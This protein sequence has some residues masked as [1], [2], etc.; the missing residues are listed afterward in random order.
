MNK[1]FAFLLIFSGALA[2]AEPV[3]WHLV[4]IKFADGGVASGSFDYDADTNTYSNVAVTST[5]GDAFPGAEY[6][7]GML[8]AEFTP[9]ATSVNFS[10][11]AQPAHSEGEFALAFASALTNGGGTV[12][13]ATEGSLAKEGLCVEAP[14][15]TEQKLS[16]NGGGF[17]NWLRIVTEGSVT[18]TPGSG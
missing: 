15:L 12:A 9:S 1:L 7:F 4:D 8:I 16:C 3:R 13:V 17:V 10:P 6:R 14:L 18:S 11:S 5:S 2:Q